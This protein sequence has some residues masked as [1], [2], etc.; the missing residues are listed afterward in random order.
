[1][2]PPLDPPQQDEYIPFGKGLVVC[3]RFVMQ[4]GKITINTGNH[5]G[6]LFKIVRHVASVYFV[7]YIIGVAV[8]AVVVVNK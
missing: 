5:Q 6:T 7:G 3:A 4:L 1:M 8:A 2:D